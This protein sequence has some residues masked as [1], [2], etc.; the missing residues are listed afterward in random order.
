[1]ETLQ[2]LI[3]HDMPNSEEIEAVKS[4][5][6]TLTYK[7][8]RKRINQLANAMLQK[9]IQKGDRVALLCKNGH[10][11]STV[12]FA[13]LEIGAVVVPVSWQLK[14]Y[15]MTGILKASE[16]KAMFYGAEFKETLDEVLPELSS[17]CV[18]METGTAYETSAEFE[19]LFA[20]PDHLP[21][22][23]MVSPDDTALLMFT[24]GTTGN[25]KR[26]MITH[27]GIYRY[28][29]K[30][31]SSIARMKGLRFLACHPIYHTSALICIML[32]TF[33][34]TTFVFTKDQDPVHILKVIEEEKI[35]TVMALPVFYTY[36]LEAWETHQTDLSSLVIL[37]TGGT[38]VPSS[39][40]RRYLDIG[41]PLA[42]GYGS[43]EAWG[44]STWLPEMG[45]DK[46]ASA[47]KPVAGVKVKVED[48]LTGEE[49]PQ[50]EIGEIVVHTPF[51]FKGYEDNPEATAKVLQ[52]GW[53]RTGDSG[54]VDEDGFIFITGR[55]KDVIIYG[56]DNVYP[57]QVEEVIQ[58]IP[59]IL[60]TAVVGIPDPLY[61]EKPKAF[62]VKNGGQRI[63]EEDVIAFCKE[64]LSAYK[65]PEVEFVNELPKNNLGKVKKDVLRNQA[66]HS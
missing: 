32:G 54:Y 21:E 30:S 15:E 20:G 22:T 56:G 47:G 7:G 37:M 17:L 53:F 27:G 11:A 63:T 18:T 58:Q 13:A 6:H 66:V 46:A 3:L 36:L 50:G 29:K 24:S 16:P 62:I 4:G 8:Y 55:Y 12:M 1:M 61:G 25:P 40:I 5:D 9:G 39:L 57:D 59:G 14:P 60:E 45:M 44:I 49:L 48:P 41:I 65:I 43:T 28:V 2:H 42:H 26:C 31:N 52:N 23:E 38:K 35:Q 19:A 33:A 10:P 34:E 51:L 64:R